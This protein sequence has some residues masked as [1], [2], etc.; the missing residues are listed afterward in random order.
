M[1]KEL[2]PMV[3][4]CAFAWSSA[5]EVH[6]QL[7][8]SLTNE[9]VP[10]ATV[11]TNFGESTISNEEG[12]FRLTKNTA[13][14]PTDSLFISCMGYRDLSI[15]T[16][17]TKDSLLYLSPKEI[18][19][20]AVILSQQNLS[21]EEIVKRTREQ[22]AKKYDLSLTNK[23]FFLRE[24][25]SQRWLQRDMKI[26][27][28]SIKEFKQSFWDSLFRTLPEKETYHTESLGQLAGNWT[29][30]EQKLKLI[31]AVNLADTVNAKGYDLIEEKITSILDES[32]KE[33]SYFKFKSGIF[34]TKIDRKEVIE[35]EVDTLS[36]TLEEQ[37]EKRKEKQAA[38]QGFYKRRKNRL[39]SIFTALIKRDR[40]DIDVLIKSHLYDYELVNFT[41]VDDL[42]VY[43]IRF[44]PS[45]SKG[46]YQGSMYIDAD[47]FSLVQ[48]EYDNVKKLRDFSLLG[49][50]YVAYGRKVK[51]KFS[52]FDHDRYQLEFLATET[53]YKT[54]IDRPFKIVEKNKYVKGRRKQNELKGEV[55]FKLDEQS[56]ITLVVFDSERISKEDYS[57]FEETKVF[58]AAQ[59]NAYDP[60]FWEG[61]TIIEPN[62]AIKAFTVN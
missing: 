39:T 12:H 32:V 62:K 29:E 44:S 18:E 43:H 36:L 11:L 5:Q 49:F 33:N 26:Q 51:I 54:G 28:S 10:F 34:S 17:E 24:S 19:L 40:L 48:L 45:G 37:E 13:L 9:S 47:R 60:S 30:E 7:R 27:K 3:L 35:K 50:S 20:N 53:K 22:V 59:R 8:D 14:R 15:S 31:R 55:H 21:A 56:N 42:P 58:K 61:Y 41:Y 38:K 1:K 23:T 57:S 52:T 46:K 16:E 6:Y 4:F 2:F 25:F